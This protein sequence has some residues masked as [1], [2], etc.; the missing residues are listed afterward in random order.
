MAQN[1]NPWWP[2]GAAPANEPLSGDVSQWFRIFSPSITVEG[3]GDPDLEGRIVRDVATYGAQLG[4]ISAIVLALAKGDPAP[5]E[6]VAKLTRIVADIDTLKASYKQG[7]R[8]RARD[9][10]LAL[11]EDDPAGYAALLGSLKAAV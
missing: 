7:A 3:K 9:A 6:E 8:D 5:A 10:M 11:R 2:W 1:W 4:Q